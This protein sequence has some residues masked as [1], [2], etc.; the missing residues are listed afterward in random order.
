MNDFNQEKTTSDTNSDNVP[1][2]DLSMPGKFHFTNSTILASLSYLGPLVFI[3]FIVGR[4]DSFV[5]FHTKQGLIVFAISVMCWLLSGFLMMSVPLVFILQII[6][7]GILILIV[8]GILNA[9]QKK[10]AILPLVG[11]YASHIKL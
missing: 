1:K 11:K 6:N 4:G 8:I 2:V 3:P 5:T 7:I 9:L 10:E